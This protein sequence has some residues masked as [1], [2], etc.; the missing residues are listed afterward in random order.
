MS[1]SRAVDAVIDRQV[2]DLASAGT[3]LTGAQRVAVAAQARAARDDAAAEPD[4]PDPLLVAA[5]RIAAAPA[6]ITA[7]WID[8]LEADGLDRLG[9]VEVVGIVARLAAI[10]AYVWAVGRPPLELP[11]G[12]AGEPTCQLVDGA[13]QRS[14]WVP[15]AGG[16][17]ATTTLSAV[18][19]ESRA[20][21]ELSAVLYLADDQ[22]GT[23]A[24]GGG[25]CGGFER[26]QV[27]V[28]AARVSYR[29]DCFY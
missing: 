5:H 25:A 4:R 27:E 20:R 17:R 8:Q 24:Q 16:A 6:T 11:A 2:A 26:A 15:I 18:A 19:A 28:V 13:R 22:V 23:A 10:D 1:G 14:A 21:A 9:Y 29:N 3:W 12:A 7:P